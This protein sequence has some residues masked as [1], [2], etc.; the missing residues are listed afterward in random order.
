ML[1][2]YI[3]A[4]RYDLLDAVY[5]QA[6]AL[7]NA[8]MAPIVKDLPFQDFPVSLRK[9][10]FV[11]QMLPIAAAQARQPPQHMSSLLALQHCDI[12][13]IAYLQ[14]KRGGDIAHLDIVRAVFQDA[15]D[16]DF[17]AV[18]DHF[19]LFYHFVLKPF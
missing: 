17:L 19:R 4:P 15:F 13:F 16:G 11:D 5:A 8:L 14:A 10:P 6:L 18:H 3:H 9:N 1:T 12:A 7:G 2:Q